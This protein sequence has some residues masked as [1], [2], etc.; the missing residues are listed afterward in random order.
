[1]S[2]IP[3]D[4][5]RQ[6]PEFKMLT[7]GQ[8]RWLAAYIANGYDARAAVKASYPQAKTPESIRVMASRIV[9]S[10][11]MVMLL[12]MHYGTDPEESFC[13]MVA[14]MVM[15]GRI[16]K[17]QESL[18]RLLAQVRGFVDPWAPRYD[19]KIEPGKVNTREAVKKRSQRAQQKARQQENDSAGEAAR[20]PSL[21]GDFAKL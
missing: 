7:E 1:M 2:R 9:N 13:L 6:L 8:Q 15:R 16:T 14:K 10:P 17:E 21:L 18:V 3:I 5:L 11:G 12:N 20:G 4:Q 19:K